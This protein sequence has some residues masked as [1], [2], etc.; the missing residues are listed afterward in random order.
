MC[1]IPYRVQGQHLAVTVKILIGYFL[2]V[3]T[4]RSLGFS[5]E[6]YP[7][8]RASELVDRNRLNVVLILVDDLKPNLGCYGDSAAKSPHIDR[9]A[10]RGVRFERAY[11]NQAVC[12]PS[13][14]NLMLGARST[15][16]GLYDLGNQLRH[17]VPKAI[18][19]PQHFQNA[20]YHTESLGKVFHIGHGNIGD[21]ESFVSKHHA[22]KVIEYVD[23]K[24]DS[25]RLL[26]REEAFFTN[27]KLGEINSL[28]KGP[29]YESPD[30][31]DN[32]Y[33]DGRVALEA[34]KRLETAKTRMQDSDVPFFIAIGFVRPHL[35]FSAPKKYWDMHDPASLP[36]ANVISPPLRA[37]NVA[38]RSNGELS[39][40]VPIPNNG[41]PDPEVAKKLVH[42]YYA[43]T[44]F[45]DAQIGLVL[46][47]LDRL[48]LNDNT[49][50]VLWGDH[51]FHLGDHGF[52]TKHTN[53]E[54]ACR[55][56]LII[57]APGVEPKT[58]FES[59][60]ETV[61]IFPTLA[62]LA[63]LESPVGPQQIDGLSLKSAMSGQDSESNRYAYHCFPRGNSLG[64]AIRTHRYR[65][66]EWISDKGHG[67]TIGVELYDFET[68]P[69]EKQN[70]AGQSPEVVATLKK[71]LDKHTKP[72]AIGQKPQ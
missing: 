40:Y 30:V 38:L 71:I 11:C 59:I 67:A 48:K 63:G 21:P 29:A 4:I 61:D 12:A 60:A 10:R 56:P 18:T 24:S 47:A 36:V 44:S 8:S 34:V 5:E 41:V 7:S 53:Y 17:N 1:L 28:P 57:C 26:T 3:C 43:S 52:W 72:V 15:S 13:R 9:L 55:I 68:D 45:V 69:E 54:H 66:V 62:D 19:L 64:L 20:G 46:D 16:T 42:G 6:S 27:Q 32:A 37:P 51:G 35:P 22:D 49:I 58:N 65:Y 23:M 14:F 39:N 25:E 33:A 70:I 31:P 50:V 2:C